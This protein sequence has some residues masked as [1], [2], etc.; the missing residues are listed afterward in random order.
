MESSYC[1]FPAT[2][3]TK[4]VFY[5]VDI[6]PMITWGNYGISGVVRTIAD[7]VGE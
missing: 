7:A 2:V 1:Q 3:A 6:P 5:G 4:T